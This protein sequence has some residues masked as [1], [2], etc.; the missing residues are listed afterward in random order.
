[1]T[2]EADVLVTGAGGFVGGH[3]AR[4][5]AAAGLKVRGLARRPPRI[6]PEDPAIEW[7][8]GDLTD[9]NV[10]ADSL[11]DVRWVVHAASWVSLGRDPSGLSRLINVDLTRLM[12]EEAANAGVERVVYTSTLHTLAAGTAERP[13]GEDDPWNLAGVDS[14]Y[15]RTK[16]EAERIALDG[17][18][19]RM[20]TVVLCPGMVL[21]SRDRRPTSTRVLTALAGSG[22]A[23]LPRGGIPI[24]DARVAAVAHLRALE[25]GEPGRR[26]AIAGPYLTYLDIAHLVADLTGR[27]RLIRPLPDWLEG[28]LS[29][30]ADLVD[31]LARGRVSEF[32][33]ASVAGAFLRLHVE[34]RRADEAFGLR[35]PPPIETIYL[36]LADARRSGRAP[37]MRLRAPDGLA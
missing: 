28:P 11:R 37:R 26:Y 33:R 29:V 7:Q 25:L 15:C 5:I 34:G 20:P 8:I 24:I 14:P 32:S 21:G 10:R 12:L 35:H 23:V 13:A 9:P 3:I 4:T 6:E 22:V 17:L 2:R 19:G 30:A 1:M 31:R 16:R 36:A 27:P 18:G